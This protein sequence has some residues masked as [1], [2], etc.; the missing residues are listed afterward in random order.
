M[1]ASDLA[2]PSDGRNRHLTF[3]LLSISLLTVVM[4]FTMVSVS[5]KQLTTD[6][7]APLSWS[8]WVLT[9]FTLGQVIA[10]PVAGRLTQR[11]G[12]RFVFAGGLAVFGAASLVCA[13][14]PNVYVMI[15][16]RLDPGHCGRRHHPGGLIH[17]R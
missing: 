12:A 6:L 8:G 13:G 9:T 14:A 17:H 15:V 4:Q 1:S 16:A 2:I 5:L 10:Q 3:A 11:L 7:N